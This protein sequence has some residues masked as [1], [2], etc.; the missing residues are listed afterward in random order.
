MEPMHLYMAIICVAVIAIISAFFAI[1]HYVH[2]SNIKKHSKLYIALML[3]ND[4]YNPLLY[5]LPGVYPA[6]LV[7]NSLQK[8]RNND[9]LAAITKYLCGYVRENEKMWKDRFDKAQSNKV[10]HKKYTD[11]YELH[12]K[13]L[14]GTSYLETKNKT[15]LSEKR[16]KKLEEKICEANV[17]KS[18]TGLSIFCTIRYTSP[19]GQNHYS[20]GW[21]VELS[22]IL[23]SIEKMNESEQ[24]IEYQRTLMT[25]SKRYDI[26]KRDNFMCK[27]CG[28]TADDGAKLEV[29]HIMPVSKG[30]KTKDSN[31]QTLCRECNQGKKAKI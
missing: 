6:R 24:S 7:C 4:K 22:K 8:Y 16:Y 21:L 26:L 14:A 9:N 28:R 18:I 1:R 20:N 13:N 25:N 12:K 15:L 27:I 30:G 3:L 5:E 29:D 10:Q 17:L 11:E 31:L 23:T 2:V 19:K